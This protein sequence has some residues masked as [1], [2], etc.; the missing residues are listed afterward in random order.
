MKY[1]MTLSVSRAKF[2]AVP[3]KNGFETDIPVI[4]SLGFN[5]VELA[6]RDPKIIDKEKIL[7]TAEMLTLEIPA[8]GTGQAWGEEGLS[9]TDRDPA[10]RKKAIERTC[11]HFEFAGQAQAIVIIGLLRGIKS[12]SVSNTDIEQWMYKAFS[13][14]CNGAEKNNVK[15]AF[16]PLNRY[17]TNILNNVEEGLEFIEKVGSPNLGML[18]DTFHMNIEEPS[19]EESIKLA[20]KRIFHFHYADSNRNYPG[21]GHLDFYSILKALK[22]TGYTGFISGEHR[23]FPNPN[24]SAQKG[25]TYLKNIEAKLS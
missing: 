21:H 9:Y 24:E 7:K 5:G 8:I 2:E 6:I 12:S 10:I 13:E 4:A 1:S 25:L 14:I 18:L 16:E 3:F 22:Q 17:E 23:P 11:E 19:I 15:I 20:G